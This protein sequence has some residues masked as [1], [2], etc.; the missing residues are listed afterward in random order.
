MLIKNP[1]VKALQDYLFLQDGQCALHLAAHNKRAE[2][3]KFLIQKGS[4]VNIE[5]NV[6][7]TLYYVPVLLP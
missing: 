5:D 6:S 4:N 7:K 1:S 3:L 2:I